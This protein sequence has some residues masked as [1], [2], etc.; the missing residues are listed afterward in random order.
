MT[1]TEYMTARRFAAKVDWE[2]GVV[3]ALE[4]GLH[5]THLDPDDETSKPLREAWSALEAA[6]QNAK[7]LIGK[8]EGL[9]EDIEE[10]GDEGGE[11]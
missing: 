10:D 4:Y 3:D 1:T 9:L 2:G 7:P 8:V 5:A 11:G 6:W